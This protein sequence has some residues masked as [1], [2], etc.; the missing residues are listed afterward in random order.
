MKQSVASKVRALLEE[1][2][3]ENGY[4]IWDITFGK[5]GSEMLL[6][7]TVDRD[8]EISL[9][10]L[11]KLNADINKILDE[12]DP[13]EGAYSLMLESAGAERFLKN[14]SH[15]QF[16][17]DKNATVSVKLYKAL[18]GAKEFE[19]TL[20]AFNDSTITVKT[21]TENLTFDRKAI[22]K[23]CAYI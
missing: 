4:R 20:T 14:A 15:L 9:D 10:M 21:E 22:S 12:A 7:V 3:L 23:I 1:T 5:E 11:S 18:N 2:I 17:L 6:T 16:A 13:I 19:G 8:D